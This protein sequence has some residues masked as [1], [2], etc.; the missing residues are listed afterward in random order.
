MKETWS[1]NPD[2][3]S[4]F[5]LLKNTVDGEVVEYSRERSNQIYADWAAAQLKRA[6]EAQDPLNNPISKVQFHAVLLAFDLFDRVEQAI[7]AMP[8]G[9]T[10][11]KLAQ[12]AARSAFLHANPIHRDNPLF[13]NLSDT[14]GLTQDDIDDLW[15]VA[16]TL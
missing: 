3:N 5:P 7:A 14:V 1:T 12:G 8:K 13:E 11:E 16:R 2:E 6:R 15:S 10:E 9:T 4:S